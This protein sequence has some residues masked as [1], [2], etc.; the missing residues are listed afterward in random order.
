M[1]IF[2]RSFLPEKQRP[3]PK[4]AHTQQ[5]LTPDQVDLKITLVSNGGITLENSLAV[6]QKVEHR[7]N[8]CPSHFNPEIFIARYLDT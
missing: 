2:D 4:A 6:S 3:I 5:Q 8:L 1:R 7:V